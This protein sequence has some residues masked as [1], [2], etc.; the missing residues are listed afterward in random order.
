MLTRMGLTFHA[1]AWLAVVVALVFAAPHLSLALSDGPT[2]EQWQ[3]AS[4]VEVQQMIRR[5]DLR[6][7]SMQYVANCVTAGALAFAVL[8]TVGWIIT[9][10]PPWRM[11][12]ERRS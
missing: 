4:D 2:P 6:A 1:L 5:A 11:R 8:A 7:D 12:G 9:G 3:Q 10:R